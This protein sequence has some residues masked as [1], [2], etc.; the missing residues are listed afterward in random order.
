MSNKTTN[1]SLETS[2]ND[3][4]YLSD[5][6]RPIQ[7]T[8]VD[9]TCMSILE[10]PEK[11]VLSREEL[12]HAALST[13]SPFDYSDN[14]I[15]RYMWECHYHCDRECE[16]TIRSYGEEWSKDRNEEENN[17]RSCCGLKEEDDTEMYFYDFWSDPT[18]HM[19]VREYIHGL[20]EDETDPTVIGLFVD[21]HMGRLS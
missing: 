1:Y 17:H 4:Q 19:D 14:D 3:V 10:T 15:Y 11:P 18:Y 5:V 2:N 20:L 12:Y 9:S 6:S 8:E 21:Y 7:S 16:D 13:H